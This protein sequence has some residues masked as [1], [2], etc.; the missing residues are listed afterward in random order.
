[1]FRVLFLFLLVR[2]KT[3]KKHH[4]YFLY[5]FLQLLL[6]ISENFKHEKWLEAV[7]FQVFVVVSYRI[8]YSFAITDTIFSVKRSRQSI[9]VSRSDPQQEFFESISHA[10]YSNIFRVFFL[11]NALSNPYIHLSHEAFLNGAT[12]DR[13][14]FVLVVIG[15]F[16]EVQSPKV[17]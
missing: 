9:K 14:F 13:L 17:M 8:E 7:A 4:K 11:G 5:L 10:Q 15:L 1:M 16:S 12:M 2:E 3:S 6:H